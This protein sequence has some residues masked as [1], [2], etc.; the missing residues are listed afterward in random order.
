MLIAGRNEWQKRTE[1]EIE[2][3]GVGANL[4]ILQLERKRAD[5]LQMALEMRGHS[6]LEMMTAGAAHQKVETVSQTW[7]GSSKQSQAPETFQIDGL[8]LV[9][10]DLNLKHLRL[11]RHGN[12]EAGVEDLLEE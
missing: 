1:I 4:T 3:G 12:E 2:T 10:Q 5:R 9:L 7:W 11:D 6:S 8:E